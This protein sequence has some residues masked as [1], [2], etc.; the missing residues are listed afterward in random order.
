M[1]L[2][3]WVLLFILVVAATSVDA[4]VTYYKPTSI[5]GSS[6]MPYDGNPAYGAEMAIDADPG[7]FCCLWDDTLGDA[8]WD[9]IPTFAEAPTTGHIIFDLGQ[10]I[11]LTGVKLTGRAGSTGVNPKDVEF[12]YFANGAAY[13]SD[14]IEGDGNLTLITPYSFASLSNGNYEET[15]WDSVSTQ[16][17]GMRV[18]SSHEEGPIHY[19][20]QIGEIDFLSGQLDP[21]PA[22][23]QIPLTATPT[24]PVAVPYSSGP[25]YN[26]MPDYTADK[27]IDGNTDTFCC[28]WDD[29]LDGASG[30]TF[31]P[32]AAGPTTGHMVFDL[33][34]AKSITGVGFQG[35][36]YSGSFNPKNVD[37][38]YYADD[39][40]SNNALVD[41]IEGDSDI[42]LIKSGEFGSAVNEVGGWETPVEARYIGMRVNSSY[43]EGPVHFNYQIAEL[44]FFETGDPN[45]DW[46]TPSAV[47]DYSGPAYDELPEWGA[48]NS[49]DGDRDTV[50]VLWDDTLTGEDAENTAPA[51]GG[52]P[53]TGH[54]VFD[55]GTAETVYGAKI[56]ARM[57]TYGSYTP[58]DV[59]FFYYAD[60]DPTNNA[61]ADDIEGDADIV[62]L[63][64][65]EFSEIGGGAAE[66][67][68]WDGVTARYIGM[69][70]NSS[71]EEGD[72]ENPEL[73][74]HY[75]YQLAEIL[76]ALDALPQE[77]PALDGDLDGDGFVGSA[78]LD[79]VRGAWGQTVA[80]GAAE[81]D[82]SN[83]GV[84][85]SA[86]LDIV[87][88]NWGATAGAAAV[89][90]PG[91]CLL[92]AFGT[93][94]MALR[95]K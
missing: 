35:G 45:I 86:D 9:A 5:V 22:F 4:A 85:G 20:F 1:R 88:A 32:N 64:S 17:V 56:L 39:D 81:G 94:I 77:T 62:L 31:P 84:V 13:D 3:S 89:P 19:N 90:E 83:D 67:V 34:E 42:V 24:K 43:E 60:D 48:A 76:F 30:S 33:G 40:P 72:E 23:D 80:G 63:T 21:P 7:T 59:E 74:Q 82:P 28:L 68:A 6:G 58:K 93:L 8:D 41:D 69:R 54:M 73:L 95:R 75:N 27:T 12:F 14:D 49:I 70:V 61:L 16:Y 11:D 71:Y 55:L 79:I 87:R 37:F 25:S 38:F 18:N 57:S 66:D 50:C 29:T 15:T 46:I 44:E 2:L 36:Q 78:D 53:T 51:N 10:V 47:A 65:H 92:I 91:V 26:N 52:G